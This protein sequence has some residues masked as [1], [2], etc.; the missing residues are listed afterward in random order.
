MPRAVPIS[1]GGYVYGSTLTP[2]AQLSVP[3]PFVHKP[4]HR[5]ESHPLLLPRSPPQCTEPQAPIVACAQ[6]HHQLPNS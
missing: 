4:R 2:P 3:L 1:I 6:E 5:A